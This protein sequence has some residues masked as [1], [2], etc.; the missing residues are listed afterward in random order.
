L[1]HLRRP[2]VVDDL[3]QPASGTVDVVRFVDIVQCVDDPDPAAHACEG[4]RSR[5]AG[6]PRLSALCTESQH[7]SVH[8]AEKGFGHDVRQPLAATWTLQ[9]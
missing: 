1:S 6:V 8:S 7:D 3:T 4:S 5:P 9:D 2:F